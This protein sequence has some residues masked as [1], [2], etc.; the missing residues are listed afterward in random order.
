VQ[1]NSST[2]WR[3]IGKR[4]IAFAR[5]H[6]YCL[7][8]QG[9]HDTL[10]TT[11]LGSSVRCFHIRPSSMPSRK[12]PAAATTAHWSIGKTGA[13]LSANDMRKHAISSLPRRTTFETV[14]HALGSHCQL[15]VPLPDPPPWRIS[16]GSPRNHP[17]VRQHQ[18][19]PRATSLHSL[20]CD[21]SWLGGTTPPASLHRTHYTTLAMRPPC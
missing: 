6:S 1:G 7:H 15:L 20:H 16:N 21:T 11:F 5:R 9:L 3:P 18:Q 12:R 14:D 13:D 10:S 19:A 4:F 2:F 17:L 8:P